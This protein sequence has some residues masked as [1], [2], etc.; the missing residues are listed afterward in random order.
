VSDPRHARVAALFAAAL[1]R[2]FPARAPFL[3][4]AAG[5]DA[6]LLDEVRSLLEHHE[7][8]DADFLAP[9]AWS[10]SGQEHELVLRGTFG[11]YRIEE[12]IGAGGMGVVYRAEQESPRR[13]VALKLLR[14]G[15][16]TTAMLARFEHEAQVLGRLQHPGI[17]QIHEAATVE[18]ETGPQ[19][20]FAMEYVRGVALTQFARERGLDT[21]AR[22]ELL[23][24]VC[25]A[26]QHA[27]A[28][29]V[30]HRDLKPAN[31]LVDEEGRAKV[32]DFGVARATDADVRSTGSTRVGEII[33]TLAYMSPEQA[34]GDPAAVDTRSDVYSL[35]VLGY[36]LLSGRMP[37]G[38]ED[39]PLLDAARVIREVEPRRL[40]AADRALAGD[41]ATIFATALE[42]ER[43]RRYATPAALA[44]DLRRAL[45]DLPIAARPPSALYQLRKFSR[46]NRA[47]VGA[48]LSVFAL[49]LVAALVNGRLAV[50]LA[51]E[52]D[53]AR[54]ARDE[55]ERQRLAAEDARTR[56]QASQRAAEDQAQLSHAISTYLGDVLRRPQP[57]G[58]AGARPVA[59]AALTAAR[60]IH[61]RFA[62]QPRYAAALHAK[63][64]VILHARGRPREA[65][66]EAR[67]AY[68]LLRADPG[69][70][71]WALV[72]SAAILGQAL[73]AAGEEAEAV[74]VLRLALETFERHALAPDALLCAALNTLGPALHARE[75]HAEAL[76][77][78]R[79]ALELCAEVHGPEHEATLM[80]RNNLASLMLAT[81]QEA[82]A[83][84][85]LAE[86]L[87][88]SRVRLTTR[89]P[90]T[91][92]AIYNYADALRRLGRMEEAEALFE[93]ALEFA[94]L[95][96]PAGHWLAG[97]YRAR[98]GELLLATAR[99]EAAEEALL[100]G[101]EIL[102]A[103]LGPQHERTCRA[104]RALAETYAAL[105]EP[106]EA[107]RW[108][109]RAGSAP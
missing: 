78:M 32:L 17:A 34:T 31:I 77:V 40:D 104:A 8:L 109:E 75:E 12:R 95:H 86:I 64:A 20:F 51:A 10:A 23:I 93:E 97:L 55:A 45:E 98:Y 61:A 1:A 5:G 7:R 76:P 84:P 85:L 25:E 13:V 26:V 70:D 72:N 29:G 11:R 59:D 103:A 91:I 96:L 49:A 69:A 106:E 37:Y 79:R 47:L 90:N 27:H 18:T 4:D 83:A 24:Q 33:G 100:E 88:T 21:A 28:K 54:V 94:E 101:E 43:E 16:A 39:R 73:S 56:A 15:L 107:A 41:L 52:R 102:R 53:A 19:P 48:T 74:A 60:N 67:A 2:P 81:G 14:P 22:V 65:A 63:A 9:C 44:D 30:V 80:A 46:R 99:V 42:K 6:E 57:V 71:P 50:R 68:E 89:H 62:D 58:A 82:E 92:T 36:E 3:L 108:R 66:D 105:G 87:A 38:H 35:G